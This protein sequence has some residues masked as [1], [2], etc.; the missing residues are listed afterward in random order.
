MVVCGAAAMWRVRP[1]LSVA[2]VMVSVAIVVVSVAIVSRGGVEAAASL[3]RRDPSRWLTLTL[4]LTLA[5][6]L[7]LAL[8]L[9]LLGLVTFRAG[10]DKP[11]ISP[12]ALRLGTAAAPIIEL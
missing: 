3:S 2:S 10:L 8:T 9:T 4:T 12:D 11:R 7:P 6:A 5:L 1:I